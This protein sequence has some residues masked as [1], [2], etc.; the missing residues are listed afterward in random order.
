MGVA[1]LVVVVLVAPHLQR[2][3]ANI[4]GPAFARPS[5]A[6]AA[7]GAIAFA[8]LLCEGSVADWSA[9]HLK[10]TLGASTSV[11]PLAL[12]AFSV[13][14]IIGRLTSDQLVER[15]GST[16][17]TR[18]G[19]LIAALGLLLGALAPDPATAI[20]GF[21]I[22]GIGLSSLF[23]LAIR[24]AGDAPG[25]AAVSSL[26]YAGLVTGPPLIG[27]IAELTNLRAA[28]AV[29]LGVLAAT[30]VAMAGASPGAPSR[31][32]RLQQ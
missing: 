25:I 4:G 8:A 6:L 9:V 15:I 14:M 12:A 5:R 10:E 20:A 2:G 23:P 26:G 24:Q 1:A 21:F 19:G 28:L 16:T 32:R 18:A 11:A 29:T 17:L 31:R 13:T 30:I 7:L 27:A 22:A 3:D